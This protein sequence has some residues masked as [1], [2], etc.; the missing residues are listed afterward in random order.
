MSIVRYRQWPT[1]SEIRNLLGPLLETPATSPQGWAPA[2]DIREEPTQFV[3]LADLPGVEPSSIEVQMDKG[4]LEIRGERS[5]PT[6]AGEG[7]FSRSERRHGT[8]NRRFALPDSANA[9]GI[10]ARSQNGVLEIRIP[11]REEPAPR[12]IQVQA[13][14]PAV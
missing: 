4:V 12:R 3:L 6:A 13:A 9:E 14:S 10:A 5:A 7:R 11:K 8:F 1:Q 2:V